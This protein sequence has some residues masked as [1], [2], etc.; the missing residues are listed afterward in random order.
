[1]KQFTPRLFWGFGLA[2]LL[3]VLLYAGIS[4]AGV[5]YQDPTPEMRAHELLQTRIV[6]SLACAGGA[7][8]LVGILWAVWRWFASRRRKIVT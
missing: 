3:A 7:L 1:M 2:L 6:D 5:P 8:L 4:G